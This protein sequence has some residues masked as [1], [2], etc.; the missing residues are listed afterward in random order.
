MIAEPTAPS[1]LLVLTSFHIIMLVFFAVIGTRLRVAPDD[2][3][4]GF[5]ALVDFHAADGPSRSAPRE[6]C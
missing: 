2:G 6:D 3:E 1:R 5:F 4:V